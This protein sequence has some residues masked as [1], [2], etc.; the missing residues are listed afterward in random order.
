MNAFV[1]EYWKSGGKSREAKQLRV[2]VTHSG[3]NVATV[4]MVKY[5]HAYIAEHFFKFAGA[6]LLPAGGVALLLPLLI[7]PNGVSLAVF[8][9]SQLGL[10]A[11]FVCLGISLHRWANKGFL[12]KIQ[13]DATRKEVRIGTVNIAGDFH[14]RSI[15]P[16]SDIESFF[17]V[18]SGNSSV[19]AKLKIRL[20]N[21]PHTVCV[22]EASEAALVP[23]LERITLTLRPPAMRNR[24]VR[25]KITGQFIRAS[26]D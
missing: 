13:V 12:P 23:I 3:L 2:T 20:K 8:W 17:I 6:L 5:H 24:R 26:F 16:V 19:P 9:T 18:R 11:A 14:L 7:L 4:P 21:A 25:T 15:Y 1:G 10:L 22:A